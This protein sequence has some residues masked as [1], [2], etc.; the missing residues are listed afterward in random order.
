MF[1][2]SWTHSHVMETFGGPEKGRRVLFYHFPRIRTRRSVI[3]YP[4]LTHRV[5]GRF[6]SEIRNVTDGE[7]LEYMMTKD[8]PSLFLPT[9]P[10]SDVRDEGAP[11]PCLVRV[12]RAG[13]I[14]EPLYVLTSCFPN[15]IRF[16][17]YPASRFL[18]SSPI[19]SH[20]PFHN[21]PTSKSDSIFNFSRLFSV[22]LQSYLKND[23]HLYALQIYPTTTTT[24]QDQ[25][26]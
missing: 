6:V 11:P 1:T 17:F 20:L 15:N 5:S 22:A 18:F 7:V 25:N 14:D 23:F 26:G 19:Q 12:L 21:P 16:A 3:H 4:A 9:T 2:S 8:P 24:T 10:A 13:A